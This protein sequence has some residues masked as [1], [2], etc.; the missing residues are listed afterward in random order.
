MRAKILDS[1][2]RSLLDEGE[3]LVHVAHM[4]TRHRL[5]L[6]FLAAAFVTM[7]VLSILLG[8]G[9]WGGRFGL[10]CAGAAIAAMATTEYRVLALTSDGLVLLRSSRVRQ[11]ATSLMSRLPDSTKIEPVGSNLVITDWSVGDASYSVMKRHQAAMVA[12]SQR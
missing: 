7:F 1:S 2:V 3:R 10:G 5:A 4:W 8:I 9:D 11:K 12:I 6:P